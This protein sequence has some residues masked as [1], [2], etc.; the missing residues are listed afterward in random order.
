MSDRPTAVA[1]LTRGDLLNNSR[2]RHGDLSRVGPS[3]RARLKAHYFSP[4]EYYEVVVSK[5][6]SPGTTWLDV[7]CGRCPLPG[8]KPLARILA[9]RCRLLVGLDPDETIQDNEFVHEKVRSTVEDYEAGRTFDLITLRMVAEHIADPSGTLASLARLTQPGSKVVIYTVTRWAATS[10]L[11]SLTSM[12]VHNVM[13][14]FLWAS[15]ERD[16]F[17]VRYQM[18]ARRRL[19]GLFVAHG[20]REASFH[21]L[22]DACLFWR[23]RRLHALEVACWKATETAGLPWFDHCILAVYERA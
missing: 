5:L 15:E 4:D 18:N 10:L 9:E 8:N 21:H 1:G 19:K 12:R 11:A 2:L 13:K 16:T 3:V 23:F 17:R 14:R 22:A 7:G 20:F 6:I